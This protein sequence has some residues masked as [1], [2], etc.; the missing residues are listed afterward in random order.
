MQTLGNIYTTGLDIKTSILYQNIIRKKN[1][2]IDIFKFE[3][4]KRKGNLNISSSKI[5]FIIKAETKKR[6]I[7]IFVL[8][9]FDFEINLISTK[10]VKKK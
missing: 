6:I 4:L 3:M 8:S 9:V 5:G 7:G 10:Y 2:I 1:D